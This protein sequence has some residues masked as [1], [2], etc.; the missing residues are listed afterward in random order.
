MDVCSVAPQ[1]RE[2]RAPRV[3]PQSAQV[4]ES[5]TEATFTLESYVELNPNYAGSITG[6]S[7]D[8]NTPKGVLLIGGNLVYRPGAQENVNTYQNIYKKTYTLHGPGPG[9]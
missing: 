4:A 2:G 5:A 8:T 7:D 1:I 6:T 3:R 9:T